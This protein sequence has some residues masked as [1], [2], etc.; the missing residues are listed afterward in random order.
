[1]SSN[2]E[3]LVPPGGS[4]GGSGG[5]DDD[6]DDDGGDPMNVDASG[7]QGIQEIQG[8][9]GIQ[10]IQG[11]DG[12]MAL[13]DVDLF[14]DPV[15]DNALSGL[16]SRPLPSKKLLQRL[17][18]LRTRGCCQ[19]VA[20]SRQGT[21]ASVS[22]DGMLIDLRF[23]RCNPENG[24]WDLSGPNHSPPISCIPDQPATLSLASAGAPIVHLAWAPTGNAEIAIIDALGRI[25]IANFPITLNRPFTARKWDADPV[26]DLHA[27]V[28]CY[29][30]PLGHP[31][32]R[33][34][35]AQH[36]PAR[37]TGQEYRYNMSI[38]A[39]FAPWHPNMGKSA[40]LCV[41]TN[42][43]LKLLFSQNN[44]RIEET[45]LELES[46]TSS[47]DLIT[48]AS[49]CSDKTGTLLVV[50]ATAS[51]QL[52]VLRVM[53]N[54]GIPPADP[55]AVPPGSVQLR[56]SLKES[57]VAV[58][59]WLHHGPGESPLDARMAQLSHIE[60]LPPIIEPATQ[61]S[62][63]TTSPP[64]ILTVRS[65]V[66]REGSPYQQEAQ[67][68]IDRWEIVTDQQQ[69]LHPAFEQLGSKNGATT[70]PPATNR[71]RKLDPV[72]VPK[73]ILAVNQTQLGKVICFSFSDGTVQYR[74]RVTMSEVYNEES[75]DAITSPHQAGFQFANDT[76]CLQVAF[77]PTNCSFVQLCEDWT[78][79]WNRLQYPVDDLTS[80]Q[81]IQL[82]A[83]AA[84]LGMAVATAATAG[85]ATAVGTQSISCDDT[86]AVIR[87]FAQRPEFTSLLIKELVQML[88]TNVDYSEEA[89]HD[90]LVRNVH[91]QLCLS[92]LNHLGFLGDFNPRTFHGKF[93]SLALNVR[94]IVI[95]VTI[96]SNTPS[97]AKENLNPLDEPDVVNALA[98]C[99]VW[100][101]DLLSWLTDCL[102][103]LVNDPHF[104]T[105][106]TT[107]DSKRYSEISAYL[108]SK[109][110]VSLHLLLC[111]STRG[112]LSA[113]CR[114]LIHLETVS[115]RTVQYYDSNR[116]APRQE[117]YHAY[118]K[119][120]RSISS[121]LVKVQEFDKLLGSLT[122][123]VQAMYKHG[124][125]SVQAKNQQQA[126]Q[127][128]A[129]PEQ[130]Q[131][132]SEQIWKRLQFTFELDMLLGK[133]P[134]PIFQAILRQLFISSLPEFRNKTDP[135]KLY[136]ANFDLLD[137]DDDPLILARRK[138]AGKY[139]D[140][141]K[142]VE[143]TSGPRTPPTTAN[144]VPS[145]NGGAGKGNGKTATGK[146]AS[147]GAATAPG[148][149]AAA[150]AAAAA[151]NGAGAGGDD[152]S[153]KWRR[154]VRCGSVMEEPLVNNK[155]GFTFVLGQQRKC[156]CGGNWGMTSR[157]AP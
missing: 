152:V 37:W 59:S 146:V 118:Q 2:D 114:R 141:F 7:I 66:P 76:P 134:P 16:P 126:G 74:D 60:V 128:G 105:M 67:S 129:T 15:I 19:T 61:T 124:L 94:N 90:Q 136:F 112:F 42:G 6:D 5:D 145:N 80:V 84:A 140:V 119:M 1:M 107:L 62:T 104:I 110:N 12:A 132:R 151:G 142:R 73:V 24:D 48:H 58:T 101:V 69:T 11:I 34:Y 68:I 92:V 21:I 4:P 143:L 17:D 138:K 18:E 144:G 148:Q 43:M 93:A 135:G 57:H 149:T 121:S 40:F 147:A 20:W 78:L 120:Q 75:T 85:A 86:L 133:G 79:K 63:Q 109:K 96:A 28:G 103:G 71:L 83:V 139:V 95:L 27:V 98:G 30:L 51:K 130:Q 56:P 117:L 72:V 25:A 13:D 65:Y 88:K 45:A 77:S 55:K 29:W 154:C 115:T 52:R 125:K 100:A 38:T 102:F 39:A 49:I 89:H 81:G 91:L 54:W 41:T 22:K 53:I 99:A 44:T 70:A 87:P 106:I 31:P 23:V 122:A 64:I 137:V 156:S 36:G 97:R 10:D 33:H 123:H 150:A 116:A 14:G 35:N 155:P 131:Q 26:D 32:G 113:M 127:S 46:I 157:S 47:D 8:I 153:T 50:L 111:S 82:R 3:P 9:D 108:R